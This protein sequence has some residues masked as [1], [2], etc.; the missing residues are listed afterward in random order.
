MDERKRRA[1]VTHTFTEDLDTSLE[2]SAA[3]PYQ[4]LLGNREPEQCAATKAGRGWPVADM[5]EPDT[6]VSA[7]SQKSELRDQMLL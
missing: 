7:L 5:K 4:Q 3:L 1:R 2:G 6:Q